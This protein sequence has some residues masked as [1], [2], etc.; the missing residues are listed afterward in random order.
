MD[1][2]KEDP[3]FYASTLAV[4]VTYFLEKEMRLF[5]FSIDLPELISAT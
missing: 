5:F 3:I 2:A 1:F 4:N